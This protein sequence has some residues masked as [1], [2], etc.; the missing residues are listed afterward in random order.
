[1]GWFSNPK[2]PHCGSELEETGYC[3]PYP[4][5]RCKTCIT[6]NRRE[7]EREEEVAQLRRRVAVLESRYGEG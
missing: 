2:C 3:S 1:M 6:R 5:W 4:S 7:R